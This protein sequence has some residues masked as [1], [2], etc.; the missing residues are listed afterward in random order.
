MNISAKMRKPG[1]LYTNLP[2]LKKSNKVLICQLMRFSVVLVFLIAIIIQVVLANSVNGQDIN[3]DKV[4]IGL[5]G[6]SLATGL[7]K[8]EEQSVFRFLLP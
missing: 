5:Q 7:K 4:T 1:R 8:I 6:E 3:K 2:D